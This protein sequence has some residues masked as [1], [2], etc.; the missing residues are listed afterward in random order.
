VE[1]EVGGSGNMDA[2][3]TCVRSVCAECAQRVH[4]QRAR[5][6]KDVQGLRFRV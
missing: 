1:D 3:A 5:K 6:R 2:C 4:I